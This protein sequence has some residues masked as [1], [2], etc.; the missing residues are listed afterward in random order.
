MYENIEM[1]KL[2]KDLETLPELQ[3]INLNFP[4]YAFFKKKAV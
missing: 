3:T 2:G 4:Q 1:E